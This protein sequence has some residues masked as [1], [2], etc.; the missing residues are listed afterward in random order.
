MRVSVVSSSVTVQEL[1]LHNQ[2]EIEFIL[3][4]ICP[5]HDYDDDN[6]L[7]DHHDRHTLI[8]IVILMVIMMM[9]IVMILILNN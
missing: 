4:L 8:L 2:Y 7:Q 5:R 3:T 6:Q 1:V 9:I